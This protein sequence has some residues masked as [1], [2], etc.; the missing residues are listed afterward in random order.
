MPPTGLAFLIQTSDN[1]ISLKGTPHQNLYIW[2]LSHLSTQ[3]SSK[4]ILLFRWHSRCSELF[5]SFYLF[6]HSTNIRCLWTDALPGPGNKWGEKQSPS[7]HWAKAVWTQKQCEVANVLEERCLKAWGCVAVEGSFWERDAEGKTCR[8]SGDRGD[9]LAALHALCPRES[10]VG[11][12]SREGGPG[13]ARLCRSC[14][15]SAFVLRAL[16]L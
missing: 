5:W 2:L 6:I 1:I 11:P 12:A 7:P 13:H 14:K 8:V 9:E 10:G 16:G 4:T 15:N 3:S